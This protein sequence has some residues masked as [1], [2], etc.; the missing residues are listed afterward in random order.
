MDNYERKQVRIHNLGDGSLF[1]DK[2]VK[3]AP[4]VQK[5]K[6]PKSNSE[7]VLVRAFEACEQYECLNKSAIVG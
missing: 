2:I 7:A 4:L 1:S 5:R 3:F 6:T